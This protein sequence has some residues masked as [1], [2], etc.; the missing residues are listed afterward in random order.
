M[1]DHLHISFQR[2]NKNLHSKLPKIF[3]IT[4]QHI[5]PH[6][7]NSKINIGTWNLCHFSD[8]IVNVDLHCWIYNIQLLLLYLW[9]NMWDLETKG[10]WCDNSKLHW[11]TVCRW[12][13]MDHHCRQNTGKL[14]EVF[15]V[16][17]SSFS[18]LTFMQN[19]LDNSWITS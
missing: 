10:H 19:N 9:H 4:H 8:K 12:L 13:H 18:L 15:R 17:H 16:K 6:G 1:F 14:A 7:G 5:W 11:D 3:S 2:D